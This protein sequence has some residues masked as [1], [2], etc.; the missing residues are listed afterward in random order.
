[1]E[2]YHSLYWMYTILAP[3]ILGLIALVLIALPGDPSTGRMLIGLGVYL[4]IAI[5]GG[6]VVTRHLDR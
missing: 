2:R 3:L 4:V 1:M 6:A 5:V